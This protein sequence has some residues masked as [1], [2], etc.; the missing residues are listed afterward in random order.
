VIIIFVLNILISIDMKIK[1]PSIIIDDGI[2]LESVIDKLNSLSKIIYRRKDNLLSL[3]NP[4]LIYIYIISDWMILLNIPPIIKDCSF[5]TTNLLIGL[6]NVIIISNKSISFLQQKNQI[7]KYLL[8]LNQSSEFQ[9]ENLLIILLTSNKTKSR[10]VGARKSWINYLTHQKLKT[11]TCIKKMNPNCLEYFQCCLNISK[12]TSAKLI[13]IGDEIDYHRGI[14]TIPELNGKSN[15]LDAQHRQLK[16]LKYILTECKNKSSNNNCLLNNIRWIGLIDDDTWI[17]VNRL[18]DILSIM[19]WKHPMI[20]GYVLSEHVTNKDL[21]YTSG[22]AGIF[23]SRSAFDIITP[24]LYESCPF[25][26][27]NDVTIGACSSISN[28]QRIHIPLFIPI[29]SYPLSQNIT[30]NVAT[31]HY[32]NPYDMINFTNYLSRSNT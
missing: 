31:I 10:F 22:G 20:V 8:S 2:K 32:I 21:L 28:I 26:K 15:Y 11:Q 14:V 3:F 17:N 9:L 29:P 13:A 5:I 7:P 30:S 6:R 18:I 19:N 1:L 27:Y 25:C 16:I 24:K 23:L 4:Y 12:N